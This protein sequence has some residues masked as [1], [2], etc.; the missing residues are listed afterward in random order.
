G[1]SVAVNVVP[2]EFINKLCEE[3]GATVTAMLAIVIL[4][5]LSAAVIAGELVFTLTLYPVPKGVPAGIVQETVPETFETVVPITVGLA[6]EPEAF[7]NSTVITLEVGTDP[8]GA[9]IVYGTLI[10]APIVLET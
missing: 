1:S 9:E 7:D 5:P 6:K 2:G 8:A 3:L 4:L 10:A